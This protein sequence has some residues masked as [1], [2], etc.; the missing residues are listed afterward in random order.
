[1]GSGKGQEGGFLSAGEVPFL[2]FDLGGYA[3]VFH[4]VL[5]SRTIINSVLYVCF[6]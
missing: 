6:T 5:S 2:T 1:M 3:G 4:Y